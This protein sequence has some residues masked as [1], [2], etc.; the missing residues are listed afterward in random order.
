MDRELSE[1]VTKAIGLLQAGERL[2]LAMNPEDGYYLAFSGGKD[3]QV[4]Y[5]L[6]VQAGV[7][8]KAWYSVTGN[9]APDN[10]YF[11]RKRY[12][13]VVFV[14]PGEKFIKLVE[15]KGMPTIDRRFC[16][17][18]LKERIGAGN[19]VLT[20]VRAQESR[21]RAGYARVMIHSRRV[22]HQGTDL[23][24]K[25]S[26]LE[27][28]QH[29]CIKGKDR[30]MVHPLLKFTSK[31]I[32]NYIDARRLPRNPLYEACGRVGCMFCP[33]SSDAQLDYYERHYPRYKKSI[34]AALGKN[35]AK[36]EQSQFRDA[37]QLYRWWRSKKTAEKFLA[38]EKMLL[39]NTMSADM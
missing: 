17:D 33:F 20:G 37:E 32:W 16:C 6:A 27:Q 18:R 11:I 36:R 31:D 3:S 24:R 34:I 30:V 39:E 29:D 15:K 25:E 9:D 4:L 14:H 23:R 1:K 38:E 19:V 28:T 22:E 21:K 35:L 8:F 12:P 26:W 5:D 7:K 2:A 10:V 13:G